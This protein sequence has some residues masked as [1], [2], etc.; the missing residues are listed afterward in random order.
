MSETAFTLIDASR[1][2]E[3]TARIADGRVALSP[4]AVRTALG[5]DLKPEGLCKGSACIPVR[6]DRIGNNGIDLQ[7]LA[8][9]LDR[10]LAIDAE[11]RV[12]ALGASAHERRAQ[13]ASLDAPDFEL[14]DLAGKLHRLSD[15]VGKKILLVAYASW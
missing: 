1:S 4:D 5:W 15:H 12:A 14:A 13:F 3:T 8:E 11:N 10:P 2:V 6:D 7:S 9:A